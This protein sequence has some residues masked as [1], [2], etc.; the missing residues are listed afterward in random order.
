[1]DYKQYTKK[2]MES[3][4]DIQASRGLDSIGRF[5]KGETRLLATLYLNDGRMQAKELAR[6]AGISTARVTAILN[7]EEE[8]SYIRREAINGDRRKINVI[9]T[10]TGAS[11]YQKRCQK[12]Q[13]WMTFYFEFLGEEDTNHLLHIMDRTKEFMKIRRK[14]NREE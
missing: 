7:V 3:I 10:E 6:I 13:N 12:I 5:S 4:M 8:K 14:E 2:F 1:M 11:E 9:L